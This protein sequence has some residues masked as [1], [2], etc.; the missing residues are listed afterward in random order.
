MAV[1]EAAPAAVTSRLSVRYNPNSRRT[2]PGNK[3]LYF[4]SGEGSVCILTELRSLGAE[5]NENRVN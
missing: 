3:N 2:V 5:G 1:T 4:F